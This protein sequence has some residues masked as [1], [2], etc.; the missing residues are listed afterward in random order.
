MVAM[1]LG[2]LVMFDRNQAL[3]D[4]IGRVGSSLPLHY[5]NLVLS[6]IG[7]GMSYCLFLFGVPSKFEW[8]LS[9][10]L[11][12]CFLNSLGV[13]FACWAYNRSTSSVLKLQVAFLSTGRTLQ[14]DLDR[15]TK[16]TDTG[17]GDYHS[18]F[19]HVMTET[20]VSSML[21]AI[22]VRN[23]SYETW[24]IEQKSYGSHSQYIVVT[25]L[26]FAYGRYELP[27]INDSADLKEALQK[28]GSIRC[29]DNLSAI[30]VLWTPQ[31]ETDSLSEQQLNKDY[32]LLRNF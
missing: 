9:A 12:L 28:L 1:V 19:N 22:E 24:Q 2:L 23:M 8:R 5:L 13:A 14:R 17:N 7:F 25:I 31:K 29:S 15:I 10:F 18:S 3:A 6:V 11:K 20:S 26:V 4:S 16:T 21:F 27:T 30:E 32:P